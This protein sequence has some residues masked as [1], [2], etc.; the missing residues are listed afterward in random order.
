MN[1]GEHF[2]CSRCLHELER[3]SICDRCNYDPSAP[4]D[5]YALEEGTILNQ[6]RFH[7]G[8]VREKLKI[9]YIYGAY[10]Y[11]TQKPVYIFE[12]FPNMSLERDEATGTD[13]RVRQSD[14]SAFE[15][16][17]FHLLQALTHYCDL[18]EENNTVYI[19][20]LA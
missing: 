13:V 1:I 3:E 14:K 4:V 2:Y 11:L 15:E 10:D 7:V 20:N 6:R 9:G 17:K 8:A 12:Y 16:G 5:K 19:Y 18:F